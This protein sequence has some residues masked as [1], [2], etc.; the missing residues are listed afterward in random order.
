MK[1]QT[2]P[3]PILFGVSMIMLF[4]MIVMSPTSVLASMPPA[5]AVSVGNGV[6]LDCHD[7]VGADFAKTMHGTLLSKTS[8]N[9]CESCHGPGS[10]H[11]EDG[12]PAMIIN[13]AKQDQF[14]G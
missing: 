6:C 4:C 7:D 11:V 14:D 1:K 3:Q 9:S 10:A 13:P 2:R 12:D 8:A 5:D